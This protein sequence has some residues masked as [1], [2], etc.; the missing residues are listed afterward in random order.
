MMLLPFQSNANRLTCLG[1]PWSHGRFVGV[2]A[3][4][5]GE[6]HPLILPAAHPLAMGAKIPVLL[7][8]GVAGTADEVRLLKIDSLVTRCA[9]II[10]VVAIVAGQAPESVAAMI[11]LAHMP[12]PQPAG[13]RINVP[14]LVT[15]RTVI[16]FE[17]VVA[18]L[19][20][21]CGGFGV[22]LISILAPIGLPGT[23]DAR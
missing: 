7:A 21:E 4:G 17:L 1:W 2:V 10:D 16:E 13:F 22:E 15:T 11:N 9:E 3:V 12:C 6:D 23:N 18:R 19:D 20:R 5:T 8:T 14:F